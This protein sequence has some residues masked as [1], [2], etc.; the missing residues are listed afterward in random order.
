MRRPILF[1]P[2]L[3][4]S[5]MLAG[6]L[7]TAGCDQADQQIAR[8]KEKIAVR[9]MDKNT[10]ERSRWMMWKPSTSGQYLTA[11]VAI[12][13]D[14][15]E[16]ANQAYQ[17]A[18][19]TAQDK[20]SAGY[21]AERALPVAI[22]NGDTEAALRLGAMID[23]TQ[24]TASGQLAVLVNLREAFAMEDWVQAEKMIA[25]IR[26]D[27]FGQYI[28][29]LARVWV[30]VG[31]HKEDQALITLDKASRAH[32]SF[33]P[34]FALHR[35]MIL[36]MQKNAMQADKAYQDILTQSFS[37]RNALM[38]ADFYGRENNR[39]GLDQLYKRINEQMMIPVSSET[40]A[41]SF[42]PGAPPVSAKRGFAN[43]M[44]DLA[45]VLQQEGSS[46]LAL[47]YAR[48][49][50]PD[51]I[52]MPMS[53]ILLGDIF[54]DMRSF[55]KARKSFENIRS[56]SLFYVTAQLRIADSYAAENNIDESIKILKPLAEK[57]ELKR[58]VTTQMGD[59][60]R[61]NKQYTEAADVYTQVIDTIDKPQKKDWA[62]F[63]A[64]AICYESAKDW[65][66]SEKDL[67]QA[68]KLSPDQP[69]VLNYLGYSWADKGEKLEQAYDYVLRAHQQ[70]PDDP[71]IID[72]AGW[73]LYQLG[74]FNKAVTYLEDS[75]QMLPVDPTINDHLGDAYWQVGRQQEARFQW[76]RALKNA[77]KSDEK[78]MN[79][80]REKIENGLKQRAA[81][82]GPLPQ[83][84]STQGAEQILKQLSLPNLR[85]AE[86]KPLQSP[87]GR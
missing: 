50:Q 28:Q 53:D 55:D 63:Y 48:I 22:G 16:E 74:H 45:T 37:L 58:Q 4:F 41:Q 29:P 40:F 30:L 14:D 43:I 10:S 64:R 84:K 72:S 20:A 66:K 81:E 52:D 44:F 35:A 33:R 82:Q 57:P 21:L 56:D 26:Q 17:T 15:L 6:A 39:N 85:K 5:L 9:Q 65:S 76:E 11:R 49:A 77:D 42:P 54:M 38:A 12:G 87:M 3:I 73:V 79:A 24:R 13:Q 69:E 18:I 62:L 78:F 34:M 86:D 67:E 70:S 60:L 51:L 83:V 68:L 31:Q 47:L 1:Q 32:P 59:L 7:V 27:G 36:D 25:A 80:V 71:Y 61:A 2:S 8:I 23:D 46:R 19:R 75:V